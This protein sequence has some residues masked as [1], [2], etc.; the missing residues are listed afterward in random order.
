VSDPTPTLQLIVAALQAVFPSAVYP[1][2]APD[3]TPAPF[4]VYTRVPMVPETTL[5][6]G[7][8][9]RNTRLQVDVYA[10]TYAQAVVLAGSAEA[11]LIA[12]AFPIQVVPLSQADQ[13]EPDVKLHR[14]LSEYSVWH[15]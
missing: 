8:P 13:F 11:A 7:I 2:V 12:L 4:A 3:Q 5:A 14:V 1:Q 10:S 15:N 9:V 6:S